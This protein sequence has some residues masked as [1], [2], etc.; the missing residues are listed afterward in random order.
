MFQDKYFWGSLL[1][2][3][4]FFLMY[5]PSVVGLATLLAVF[6]SQN[7]KGMNVARAIIYIPVVTSLCGRLHYLGHVAQPSNWVGQLDNS[8]LR[9]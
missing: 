2:T 9:V 1:V 4:K 5:V 6:V 7:R 3:L 8:S